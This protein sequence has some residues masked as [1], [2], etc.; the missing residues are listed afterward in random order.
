MKINV[1]EEWCN[2]GKYRK[3]DYVF[4]ELL[5]DFDKKRVVQALNKAC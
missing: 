3:N 5:K 2:Y 4:E 1:Y